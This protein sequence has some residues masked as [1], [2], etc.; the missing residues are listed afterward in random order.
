VIRST[1]G[2]DPGSDRFRDLSAKRRA[3]PVPEWLADLPPLVRW[4]VLGVGGVLVGLA[5]GGG[6]WLLLE[7]RGE[8]AQQTFVTVS[9]GYRQAMANPEDGALRTAGEA[10]RR[11]TRDYPRS[12]QATQAWYF[13]GNVEYQRR[14]FDAA[15]AAFQE[16]ARRGAGDTLAT[17]ARLGIGYAAEAKGD[18]PQALTAYRDAL[19]GRKPK[20]FLYPELMLASGRVQEQLQ[21]PKAAIETYQQLL[22]DVPDL[23]RADEVRSRLA[24]LG[25]PAA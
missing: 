1:L 23:P 8:A 17:L 25:A 22:K 4:L 15:R 21:Q 13:L 6:V 3:F 2:P 20:D 7:S 19:K 12:A 5:L 10:L 11:Y 14:D 9:A 18:L 24:L 16:A